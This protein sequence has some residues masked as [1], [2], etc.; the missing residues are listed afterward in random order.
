[1]PM[2]KI[3]EVRSLSDQELSDEILSV[4]KELFELRLQKATR[5]L[6]QPHLIRQRKHKLAQLLTVETERQ[7][8]ITPESPALEITSTDPEVAD[9]EVTDPEVTDPEVTDPEVAA[10]EAI[11]S[12]DPSPAEAEIPTTETV[13]GEV[14]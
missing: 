13:E 2:P 14:E 7:R 4:K 12:P 8:G 9:P 3:D 1:M 5:Q 6:N 11:A 10:P